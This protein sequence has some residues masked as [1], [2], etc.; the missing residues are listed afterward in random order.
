MGF[1]NI[2]TALATYYCGV[3]KIYGKGEWQTLIGFIYK[4]NRRKRRKRSE[5]ACRP[6]SLEHKKR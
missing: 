4:I 3:A 6:L 5:I 1:M 2:T